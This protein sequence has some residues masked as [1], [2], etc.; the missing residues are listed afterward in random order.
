[1]T[2]VKDFCYS[3]WL[4]LMIMMKGGFP[5]RRN[6]LCFLHLLSWLRICQCSQSESVLQ[7]KFASNQKIGLLLITTLSQHVTD[8]C[9]W[10]DLPYH[11]DTC[12]QS[13]VLHGISITELCK[14][15]ARRAQE[16]WRWRSRLEYN[17][18]FVAAGNQVSKLDIS[19]LADAARDAQTDGG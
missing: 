6:Y 13:T 4:G 8:M 3:N 10:F 16:I 2:M 9:R 14:K 7:V 12:Q 15:S 17:Y 5:T 1:M 18:F 19:T 11:L